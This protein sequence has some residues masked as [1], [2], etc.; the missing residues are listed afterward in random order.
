LKLYAEL[1]AYRDRL[2]ER[3]AAWPE[4]PETDL[5]RDLL[6]CEAQAALLE[7]AVEALRERLVV[8]PPADA[9]ALARRIAIQDQMRELTAAYAEVLRRHLAGR[10][11]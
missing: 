3:A 7:K 10:A 2:M 9:D 8:A 6:Q 5:T 4:T 1:E 11:S